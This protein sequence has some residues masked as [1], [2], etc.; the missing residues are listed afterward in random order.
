MS[1]LSKFLNLFRRRC[2]EQD[3]A[4]EMRLHRE[5]RIEQAMAAGLDRAAA[6]RE[7]ALRFGP[8]DAAAEAAREI[9]SFL[10]LEHLYQDLRYALCGMRR[11]PG[12]TTI[13]VLTLAVG[14]AGNTACFS[15]LSSVFLRPF[16]Y[17][18]SDRIVMI[19]ETPRANA[20]GGLFA[21]TFF[22]IR[23]NHDGLFEKIGAT[24]ARDYPMT[25]RGPTTRER[26]FL[27]SPETLDVFGARYRLGRGMRPEEFTAG[28]D[29][30]AVISY[31]FWQQR[32]GGTIDAV[33][34][35][36][37]INRREREIVG[38]LEP[39][40]FPAD[41]TA[42]FVPSE[43]M[44]DPSLRA[45]GTT[46]SSTVQAKLAEGV[47]LAEAQMRL[48]AL[49]STQTPD[50]LGERREWSLITQRWRDAMFT[51][52]R[53][54]ASMMT[55]IV[56]AILL[57]ACI[58]II[59]LVLARNSAR[60]GEFAL[61]L[62]L[63][64][65]SGR[66]VRQLLTETM[67]LAALG[68]SLGGWG[69]VV[70]FDFIAGWIELDRFS[71][72]QLEPDYRV[73]LFTAGATIACGLTCGLL[74]ALRCARPQL[75]H[76]IKKGGQTGATRRRSRL[77]SALVV[78]ETAC[79]IAL[80]VI[81][82]MFLRSLRN[83]AN[84]DPGFNP[85]NVLYF[86]VAFTPEPNRTPE[87]GAQTINEL[88]DALRAMPGAQTAALATSVPLGPSGH[89]TDSVYR[90]DQPTDQPGLRTGI[91]AATAEYW[92]T[93]Q[94]PL[95]RGRLL[96][97]TNYATQ[98]PRQVV[99]NAELVRRLFDGNGNAA[100]GS[101]LIWRGNPYEI[102]GIVGNTSRYNLGQPAEPQ[103]YFSFAHFNHTSNFIVRT[104]GDASTL[105]D[106]ARTVM[107][108]L[109]PDLA[110]SQIGTLIDSANR[111]LFDHVVLLR[112]VGGFALVGLALAAI[113]VFG[114]M[115]YTAAQRTREMGVRVAL[116]AT[117][118]NIMSLI[119]G[120][121]LRL[122]CIGLAIGVAL[123]AGAARLLASFFYGVSTFD[124]V[125]YAVSVTLLATIGILA[126]LL[127]AWR[128]ARA[129]PI[130]VLRAE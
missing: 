61:R 89:V 75:N 94:I 8:A 124:P 17:P 50:Q 86:Q 14:I 41:E 82:M 92:E 99:V 43:I 31:E 24:N 80:L 109:H 128:A 73:M 57:L 90:V 29:A 70:F 23:E 44:T 33:G 58:N 68:G 34:Q 101:P 2:L 35:R 46:W 76:F 1:L 79:A 120:D 87:D 84:A 16:I 45:P 106:D 115:T 122:I 102:V 119:L 111:T 85:S 112:V 55:G 51:G 129:D 77:Q 54:I 22:H 67:L 9:R 64:A 27:I 21:D 78:T 7:A 104:A 28:H 15:Y 63:G 98:A 81:A 11:A 12:F 49:R 91:G 66:I 42:I 121:S 96:H 93:L 118:R 6:E 3:M 20:R 107:R 126:A 59:N 19:D 72:L 13:V 83:V 62:A 47:S 113:G 30:V 39:K 25:G 48:N 53:P 108:R 105:I 74:P 38:I 26:V 37:V 56:A 130:A 95:L 116:G 52:L 40:S 36:I 71:M 123:G 103:C 100:L 125:S 18:D 69:G 114:V 127:P 10:W 5:H 110:I 117:R 60:T 65:S 97:E 4:E 32:L 88:L